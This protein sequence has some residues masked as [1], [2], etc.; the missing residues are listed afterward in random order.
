MRVGQLVY[1]YIKEGRQ[2]VGAY[3]SYTLGAS[4]G[5][6][7]ANVARE[8]LMDEELVPLHVAIDISYGEQA[9]LAD[10]L[11]G[12][13]FGL[14]PDFL[15][16]ALVFASNAA[17]RFGQRCREQSDLT[18]LGRLREYPG[19]IVDEAHAQHFVG[20]VEHDRL[21]LVELQR[22]AFHVIDHASRR[23]DNDVHS[24]TEIANLRVEV[25]AA[26]DRRTAEAVEP[27]AVTLERF[28]HL[29]SQFAGRCEHE[30]LRQFLRQVKPREQR[31]SKRRRLTRASLRLA[32]KVA[33][34]KQV[35]NRLRLNRRRLRV[36][37]FEDR[38]QDFIAKT[39]CFETRLGFLNVSGFGCFFV[40]NNSVRSWFFRNLCNC[41]NRFRIFCRFFR[42]GINDLGHLFQRVDSRWG[43]FLD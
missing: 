22:A 33:A 15:R 13:D 8:V 21:Q 38:F 9:A 32:E 7:E 39:E 41:G 29:Q 6:P 23:A 35:R 36:A 43:S 27:S 31:Q 4:F 16:V 37:S 5:Y 28:L 19:D 18:F 17:D 24:L 1:P 3:I 12:A 34:F 10:G 20:F 42:D 26:V 11:G 14:D 2:K 25:R 40:S 30:H